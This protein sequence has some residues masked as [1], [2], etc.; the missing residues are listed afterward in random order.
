[1]KLLVAVLLKLMAAQN[2]C[3]WKTGFNVCMDADDEAS[4][5]LDDIAAKCKKFNN[6]TSCEADTDCTQLPYESKPCMPKAINLECS[7]GTDDDTPEACTKRD[8]LC[9]WDSSEGQC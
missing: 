1:M 8:P 9:A 3:I 2:N 5:Q 6:D 4:L 7:T